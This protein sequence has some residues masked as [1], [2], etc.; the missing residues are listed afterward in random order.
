[1][2]TV[3]ELLLYVLRIFFKTWLSLIRSSSCHHLKITVLTFFLLRV[4]NQNFFNEPIV[5]F[6]GQRSHI[7]A[8]LLPTG[9]I[10]RLYLETNQFYN[11]GVFCLYSALSK[12]GSRMAVDSMLLYDF[13]GESEAAAYRVPVDSFEAF[14]SEQYVASPL[15][16]GQLSPDAS[17]SLEDA[18]A[19]IGL[20]L[21]E[22]MTAGVSILD[23]H[24][25]NGPQTAISGS[26]EE[27]LRVEFAADLQKNCYYALYSTWDDTMSLT[28]QQVGIDAND[29]LAILNDIK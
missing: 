25:A 23:Q 24:L 15:R 14:R 8:R 17:E 22:P 20:V 27:F 1:M 19:E 16:Y 7:S 3:Y 11:G 28:G 13:W 10:K 5:R 12:Q 2:K 6:D 18:L 21:Q 26:Q 9:L 4:Q 29:M